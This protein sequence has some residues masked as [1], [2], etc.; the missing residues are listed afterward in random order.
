[1]FQVDLVQHALQD[2]KIFYLKNNDF[3]KNYHGLLI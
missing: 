2:K 1:M 3:T